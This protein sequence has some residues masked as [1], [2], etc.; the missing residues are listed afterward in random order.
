M[1]NFGHPDDYIVFL[2]VPEMYNF[3]DACKFLSKITG[4][5]YNEHHI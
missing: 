5:F 2:H 3:V 4:L 1:D